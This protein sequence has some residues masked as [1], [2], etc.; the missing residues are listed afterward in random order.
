MSISNESLQSSKR[1]L[2]QQRSAI[3]L[4]LSGKSLG[5]SEL[6]LKPRI[7]PHKVEKMV[8]KKFC[9]MTGCGKEIVGKA[10]KLIIGSEGLAGFIGKFKADLCISCSATIKEKFDL[11]K[12]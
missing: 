9:D 12:R 5:E 3:E 8:K 10:M 2:Q 4:V 7:T 6:K 1:R 11:K